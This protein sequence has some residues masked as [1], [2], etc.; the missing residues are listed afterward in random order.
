MEKPAILETL[1]GIAAPVAAALGL[2]IWGI[3]IVQAGRA[4]VRIF[5]DV[6][7]GAQGVNA[8]DDAEG[9]AGAPLSAT[10]GQ[11][12]E[13]SRHVGLALE[14]EDVIPSAYVLEVSSPGLTRTIFR[15]DQLARYLGDVIEASLT[16][17]LPELGN[18][19]RFRG[20]LE[21]VVDGM[22]TLRLC[23]VSPEGRVEA[24][25]QLVSLPWAGCRKVVRQHIFVQ[26]VKPGK[27]GKKT[28]PQQG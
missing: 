8:A 24:Q 20:L 2:E 19:R 4:V 15:P 21:S 18:R 1:A 22:F 27:G 23:S 5:V 6:P 25:E 3:E 9:G 17:P 26:P 11:C 12:E 13:I 7:A 16:D 14:A 10:I 28:V